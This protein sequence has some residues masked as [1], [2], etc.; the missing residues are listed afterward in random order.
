MSKFVAVVA[1]DYSTIRILHLLLG[2]SL[3]GMTESASCEY[4]S[5]VDRSE[6]LLVTIVAFGNPPIAGLSSIGET[7]HVL[8]WTIW[9]AILLT[10]SVRLLRPSKGDGVL[11]IE[12]TLQ[13]HVGISWAELL[14]DGD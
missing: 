8:L 3:A 2:T 7:L 12:I 9:P 11:A 10:R 13:V 5:T 14:L 1:L 4:M 6:H